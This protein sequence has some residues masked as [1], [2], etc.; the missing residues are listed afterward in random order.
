MAP[1]E[2]MYNKKYRPIPS[3]RLSLRTARI[4]RW[5]LPIVCMAWSVSYSKEV[6]YASISSC[7]LTYVYNEMGYAAGHWFG[8]NFVNAVGLSSFEIGACLI[9]GERKSHII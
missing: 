8:R 2:D 6:L 5:I 7:A 9:I 1:E 3:G 4:L